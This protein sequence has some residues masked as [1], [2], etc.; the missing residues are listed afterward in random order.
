ML[1]ILYTP[2]SGKWDHPPELSQDNLDILFPL[3]QRDFDLKGKAENSS[4]TSCSLSSFLISPLITRSS[5]FS[6]SSE[7]LDLQFY[8]IFIF[9]NY[10]PFFK[11]SLFISLCPQSS[12]P[13]FNGGSTT[14]ERHGLVINKIFPKYCPHYRNIWV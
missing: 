3:F 12:C 6:P 8:H 1:S 4:L 9:S 10:R 2:R 7:W 5:F 14:V 13:S 11:I